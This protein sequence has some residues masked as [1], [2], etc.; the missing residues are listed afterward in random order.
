MGTWVERQWI[1]SDAPGLARRSR[2]GGPYRAFVPDRLSTRNLRVPGDMSRKAAVVERR[3]LDLSSSGTI[4]GL[5]GIARFLMRSE[6][7][8]SSRIEGLAPS[9]DKVAV[10]ELAKSDLQENIAGVSRIAELVANNVVA[11]RELSSMSAKHQ[12][13]SVQDVIALHALLLDDNRIQGLR[14]T[15]N[16]I[17]GSNYHP[18]DAEFVPPPEDEVP[19]LM[20][21]LLDYLNGAEHGALIQAAIVH[22]QFETIHPFGDGNGRIGRSLIHSVLQRRGLTPSPVLPVSMVLGTWSD[23]YIEGLTS[24]RAS[25]DGLP[26]WLNTFIEATSIAVDQATM[27]SSDIADLREDWAVRVDEQRSAAGKT[28]A[29]RADAA[30]SRIMVLLPDAPVLTAA[31][32]ANELGISES[33]GRLALEK[34]TEA[35]V[36]RRKSIG[37]RVTGYIA[38]ELLDLVTIAERQLASTRF[39]TAISPANA[40]AVP[41]RP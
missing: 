22:A 6:A 27:L 23:R 31:T 17:G 5:E 35:G 19:G 20:A 16:W 24:F 15:Q 39:D 4:T 21:D 10:A 34:L 26:I 30:E 36:L 7:I 13:L 18:I 11:L 33:A 3:I 28:R 37:K 40:R 29:L 2:R 9:P 41:K 1:P 38:D 14:T 25:D 12:D 8:A 32:A